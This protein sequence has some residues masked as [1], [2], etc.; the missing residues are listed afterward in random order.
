MFHRL[1]GTL[2]A[3]LLL[4]ALAAGNARGEGRTVV[5]GSDGID[6]ALSEAWMADGTLP[7]FAKLAE[8]GITKWHDFWLRAVIG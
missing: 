2:P 7:N 6:P 4:F 5:L 1:S 8:R 3:A